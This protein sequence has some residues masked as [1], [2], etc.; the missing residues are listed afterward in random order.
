METN[1]AAMETNEARRGRTYGTDETDGT[2]TNEGLL[3][4]IIILVVTGLVVSNIFLVSDWKKDK[5]L[6][7]YTC[8]FLLAI[9]MI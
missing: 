3:K 9:H 6:V 7:V 5:K 2:V 1:E 8:F 4:Y